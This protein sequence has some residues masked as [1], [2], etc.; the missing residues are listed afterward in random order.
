MTG[1]TSLLEIK[2]ITERSWFQKKKKKNTKQSELIS[3]TDST[4]RLIFLPLNVKINQLGED[5]VLM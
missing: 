5:G 1:I 2:K 4:A 3:S